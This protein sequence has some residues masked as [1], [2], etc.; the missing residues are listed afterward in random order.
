LGIVT[1]AYQV[2]QRLEGLQRQKNQLSV[3]TQELERLLL[4]IE[5]PLRSRCGDA[6][7]Q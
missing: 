1:T 4:S 6:V 3:K 7:V 5:A 2:E